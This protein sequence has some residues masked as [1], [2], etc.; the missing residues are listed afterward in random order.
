MNAGLW[1]TF[2]T[3]FVKELRELARDRRTMFFLFAPPLLGPLFGLLAGGVIFWQLASRTSGGLPVSVVNAG[4]APALVAALQA[5]SELRLVPLPADSDAALRAGDLLVLLTIPPDFEARV[6]SQDQITVSLRSAEGYWLSAVARDNVR[7]T[8]RDYGTRLREERLAAHGVAEAW[9]QPIVISQEAAATTGLSAPGTMNVASSGESSPFGAVFFPLAVVSWALSGG[10]GLIIDATVGEK[11]RGTL[12]PLI[13]TTANR[14]GIA[15]G[16]LAVVLIISAGVMLLWMMQ[17]VIVLAV[18][19]FQPA[20][21][22][23]AAAGSAGLDASQVTALSLAGIGTAVLVL[24]AVTLPLVAGMTAWVLALGAFAR[25]YREA[26]TIVFTLELGLPLVAVLA[27]FT[28]DPH[29]PAVL[30]LLPVFGSILAVRDLF[31]G[32]LDPAVLAVAL[33]G[34]LAFTTAGIVVAGYLFSR[35]WALMRGA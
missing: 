15:L 12:A 20:A 3:V 33:V 18:L 16:K 8:V 5:K 29:A 21:L 35:E 32:G 31:S 7:N 23:Q 26:N 2:K 17:G 1:H 22:Q 24:V 27:T 13:A 28:V 11:M 25:T 4:Q 19:A 34:S 30:Y 14:T 9:L 6:Q 10:L